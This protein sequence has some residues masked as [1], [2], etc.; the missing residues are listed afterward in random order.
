[1]RPQ[2]GFLPKTDDCGN[3]VELPGVRIKLHNKNFRYINSKL[4]GTIEI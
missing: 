2:Q 3:N 1:M 4:E